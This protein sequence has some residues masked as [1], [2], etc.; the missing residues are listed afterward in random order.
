[1]GSY[2]DEDGDEVEFEDVATNEDIAAAILHATNTRVAQHE[3]DNMA[4]SVEKNYLSA[5]Q[6]MED[7][8]GADTWKQI[9]DESWQRF[10]Q[11]T[12]TSRPDVITSPSGLSDSVS[13]AAW[14]IVEEKRQAARQE[15]KEAPKKA[16]AEIVNAPGFSPWTGGGS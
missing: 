2:Y 11:T 12:G 16:W 13:Q 14:Q 9:R 6:A 10:A 4:E 8:F 3:Q 5:E 15:A 1:M 7:K